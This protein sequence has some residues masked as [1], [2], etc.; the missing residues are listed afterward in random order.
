MPVPVLCDFSHDGGGWTLLLTATDGKG[1]NVHSVMG[2]NEF[3]PSL[4][5]NYA[6]LRHADAIRDLGTRD[7]FAYR[8]ETEA[9]KG[10]QRWGGVWLAPRKYSFTHDSANQTSV[11]MLEKFNNWHYGKRGPQR[12]MPWIDIQR[13]GS[14]YAVL[15]TS[16]NSNSNW[17]GTLVTDERMKSY[18]HSPWIAKGSRHSGT[19]LYWMR[20][21]DY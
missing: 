5:S 4:T 6:I 7:R 14:G 3:S 1:W 16:K 10:R 21:D 9:Q 11:R 12:R 2:R 20:E 17:W 15:T 19:I 13:K 8:I 18:R